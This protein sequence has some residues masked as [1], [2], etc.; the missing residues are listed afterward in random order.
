MIV[1]SFF[2][3][4][5]FLYTI[6]RQ[7]ATFFALF[8]WFFFVYKTN[9]IDRKILILGFIIGIT[10]EFLGVFVGSWSYKGGTP[11][12]ALGSGWA[13]V[14]YFPYVIS[15]RI[16]K[17]SFTN[18]KK[19]ITTI[20]LI[21]FTAV[22]YILGSFEKTVFTLL[23]SLTLFPLIVKNIPS[24]LIIS[25]EAI[26]IDGVGINLNQWIY[27]LNENTIETEHNLFGTAVSYIFVFFLVMM[28]AKYLEDQK[29]SRLEILS[30]ISFLICR[31]I[32]SSVFLALIP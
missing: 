26:T 1:I 19:L 15:K 11:F 17:N 13:F 9:G 24:V 18:N 10:L 20:A 21:S 5:L 22:N 3:L 6:S 7:F 32:F 28:I 16:D 8:L 25:A 4:S 27:Y 14:V 31:L 23:F 30:L 12:L 2:V 29:I